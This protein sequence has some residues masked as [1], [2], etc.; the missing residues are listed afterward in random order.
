MIVPRTTAPF[1]R[2]IAS[3]GAVGGV[4]RDGGVGVCGSLVPRSYRGG[5]LC[6]H[7]IPAEQHVRPSYS[8]AV[9]GV[10]PPI[11]GVFDDIGRGLASAASSVVGVAK[12]VV[13]PIDD[14]YVA[15]TP[16]WL[17]R[18]AGVP[19]AST[20][21]VWDAADSVVSGERI[22]RALLGAA[23]NQIAMYKAFAPIAQLGLSFI[24]GVGQGVS[25]AIGAGLALADGRPIT[26]AMLEAVKS[27]MPGGPLVRPNRA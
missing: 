10:A 7:P 20:R 25:A 5:E 23:R 26:D 8:T 22:D 9:L 15:V 17:R 18:A 14:V 13:K 11:E 12:A 19:F 6:G 27:A 4:S 24:P 21:F 3:P 1:L 16:Q 2:K